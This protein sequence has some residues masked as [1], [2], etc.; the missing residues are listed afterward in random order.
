MDA[1]AVARTPQAA[2]AP[3]SDDFP[4]EARRL[5][6]DLGRPSRA[7]YWAD[8]AITSLAL[9]AG[10]AL[11]A[12]FSAPGKRVSHPRP[13]QVCRHLCTAQPS[14]TEVF[15]TLFTAKLKPKH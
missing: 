12:W 4:A 15:Y 3:M 6:A 10:L 2:V 14:T 9:F 11:A 1:P 5:T 8:L 13:S 7:T